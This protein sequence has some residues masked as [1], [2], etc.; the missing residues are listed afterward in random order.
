MNGLSPARRELLRRCQRLNFGRIEGL[1][2]RDGEPLFDPPPRVVR[3]VKIGGRNEPR[4]EFNCDD[5]SLKAEVVEFFEHLDRIAN[6]VV[7]MLEVRAGLP[8][9]FTIEEA[10]A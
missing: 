4:P 5:F 2:I 7:E 8:C 9:R 10:T 3:E 6:G 1:I